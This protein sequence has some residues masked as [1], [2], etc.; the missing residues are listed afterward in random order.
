MV[1]W[2]PVFSIVIPRPHAPALPKAMQ[3]CGP[4]PWPLH[5][6]ATAAWRLTPKRAARSGTHGM[7]T[8][9]ALRALLLRMSPAAGTADAFSHRWH[10]HVC[11]F[12]GRVGAGDDNL[13]V[14]QLN[15]EQGKRR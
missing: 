8:N 14:R 7:R 5:V 3:T 11:Y 15:Y 9:K 2:Y 1:R 4:L 12:P 13:L 6:P 10:R